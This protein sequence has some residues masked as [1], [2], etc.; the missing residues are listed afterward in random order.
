MS[1]WD[2]YFKKKNSQ[3]IYISKPT[4]PPSSNN[5]T[6]G[7]SNSPPPNTSPY[8]PPPANATYVGGGSSSSSYS[9]GS[10]SSTSSSSSSNNQPKQEVVYD[11]G[12]ANVYETEQLQ[13]IKGG[14]NQQAYNN[15]L[16]NAS[17]L[18]ETKGQ[19]VVLDY[20]AHTGWRFDYVG[21]G[22]PLKEKTSPLITEQQ[23]PKQ[24]QTSKSETSK[25]WSYRSPNM[26]NSL[27]ND[28]GVK[29]KSNTNSSKKQPSGI[30]PQ[31]QT[32]M[33]VIPQTDF[34]T[35][36]MGDYREGKYVRTRYSPNE[37]EKIVDIVD[38]KAKQTDTYKINKQTGE[39][40]YTSSIFH[41]EV[42]GDNIK[43]REKNKQEYKE[44]INKWYDSGKRG[45]GEGLIGVWANPIIKD[46]LSEGFYQ[47]D[48]GVR[49]LQIGIGA[50]SGKNWNFIEKSEKMKVLSPV[51]E[52]YLL[53]LEYTDTKTKITPKTKEKIDV[54]EKQ[55]WEGTDLITETTKTKTITTEL[56]FDT[57]TQTYKYGDKNI[58]IREGENMFDVGFRGTQRVGGTI[59]SWGITGVGIGPLAGGGIALGT[60]GAVGKE[61]AKNVGLNAL[62][63]GA[64]FTGFSVA[65]SPFDIDIFGMKIGVKENWSSAMANELTIEKFGRNIVIG[66]G[67]G[68]ASTIYSP[69]IMKFTGSNLIKTGA[70]LG[71][72]GG[73]LAGTTFSYYDG[74]VDKSFSYATTGALIGGTMGALGGYA[75]TQGLKP[76]A[77][78]S[79]TREIN[80]LTGKT[81]DSIRG[82]KIG[83]EKVNTKTGESKFWG[84][85]VN[86]GAVNIGTGGG[87][88]T[89]GSNKVNLAQNEYLIPKGITEMKIYAGSDYESKF[90]P[91]VRDYFKYNTI[92]HEGVKKS[93]EL[94]G[95]GDTQQIIFSV[96]KGKGVFGGSS[97]E[98]TIGDRLNTNPTRTANVKD[99]DVIFHSQK[100]FNKFVSELPKGSSVSEGNLGLKG[101][102]AVYTNKYS[103]S[104]PSGTHI[105]VS[106]VDLSLGMPKPPSPMSSYLGIGTFSKGGGITTYSA[107][108]QLASKFMTIGVD[109]SGKVGVYESGK[110]KYL[111]DISAMDSK[112][113]KE[114]Q[115]RYVQIVGGE[116]AKTPPKIVW[117]ST[118]QITKSAT[119]LTFGSSNT[120][121][122]LKVPTLSKSVSV[123]QIVSVP[124]VST[125]KHSLSKSKPSSSSNVSVSS[126]IY[127]SSVSSTSSSKSSSSS[128]FGGSSSSSSYS[129][130]S[131]SSSSTSIITNI[132]IPP[133]PP[134]IPFGFGGLGGDSGRRGKSGK[135]DLSRKLDT[136]YE[137]LTTPKFTPST[138]S[139]K[140]SKSSSKGIKIEG[141]KDKTLKS[142]NLY[143]V[144][145][146]K[147]GKKK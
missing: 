101:I 109:S 119:S 100:D 28:T 134:I 55:Y 17:N 48:T 143:N 75:E 102:D 9:G 11:S 25:S 87:I 59:T 114:T 1:A 54:S 15:V 128:S 23:Q 99:I 86:K 146:G 95:K 96:N 39:G 76:V 127:S 41:N 21:I 147:R 106:V 35:N 30:T 60:M 137:S 53:D 105:D 84:V 12:T 131:S 32:E 136:L 43:A 66:T 121:S 61:V 97:V 57:E 29:Y 6:G 45:E 69:T 98:R 37:N 74:N 133:P 138:P 120:P 82:V 123:S 141:V 110:E 36:N 14:L 51:S 8:T 16:L 117:T 80:K 108:Q 13:S 42:M 27:L 22:T 46:F 107:Q 7:S 89:F 34:L 52:K 64:T 77:Q 93:L 129:G 44:N 130:G 33:R 20:G 67:L 91:F 126:S 4:S 70:V 65:L 116:G 85:E 18:A 2:N 73:A 26:E 144:L 38:Y 71:A 115:T 58:K 111:M 103:I 3:P 140:V 113:A 94:A 19:Q 90:S 78:L 122:A 40:T 112:S 72:T 124:S 49:E 88:K 63:T 139:L 56:Q 79:E 5:K 24:T 104:T 81:H 10:S 92:N 83:L 145:I 62:K 31:L 50:I 125:S 135:G 47:M 132:V 118:P 142:S 68:S